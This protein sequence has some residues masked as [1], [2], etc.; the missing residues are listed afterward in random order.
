[1]MSK[2]LAIENRN[3]VQNLIKKYVIE[4]LSLEKKINT[5]INPVFV[6]IHA[7]VCIYD[8]S[9]QYIYLRT[10]ELKNNAKG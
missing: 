8:L 10:I 5:I 9:L 6:L 1:M 4:N 7:L 3:I 2:N